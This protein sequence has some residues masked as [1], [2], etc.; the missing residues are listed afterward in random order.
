MILDRPRWISIPYEVDL[1][2]ESGWSQQSD[3]AFFVFRCHYYL[4]HLQLPGVVKV[5]QVVGSFDAPPSRDRVFSG[6]MTHTHS[7]VQTTENLLQAIAEHE[8][9]SEL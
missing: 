2:K 7:F 5:G 3:Y 9:K 8:V 1:R 4:R 6:S